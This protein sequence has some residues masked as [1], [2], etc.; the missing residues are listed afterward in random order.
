MN[1]YK[2]CVVPVDKIDN[3]ANE[4]IEVHSSPKKESV[5][6]GL[7]VS[8][9]TL[10]N[11]VLK[12]TGINAIY[13]LAIGIFEKKKHERLQTESSLI[14]FEAPVEE[15]I[16]W[17]NQSPSKAVKD[18]DTKDFIDISIGELSTA[19]PPA[20]LAEKDTKPLIL[21]HESD[22]S[23]RNTIS[24]TSD[25]QEVTTSA[26]TAALT[27]HIPRQIQSDFDRSVYFMGDKNNYAA[28]SSAAVPSGLLTSSES[29]SS[30]IEIRKIFSLFSLIFNAL[31][32]F[33]VRAADSS[34]KNKKVKSNIGTKYLYK[35]LKSKVDEMKPNL[36]EKVKQ[37]TVVAAMLAMTQV[38]DVMTVTKLL[39]EYGPVVQS[40]NKTFNIVVDN[41]QVKIDVHVGFVT[42]SDEE[43]LNI[44]SIRS[45]AIE[46]NGDLT[47]LGLKCTVN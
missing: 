46:A 17:G 21:N 16:G 40:S 3:K 13:H 8:F 2:M 47:P 15:D 23:L 35:H 27:L 31:S 18:W 1:L 26:E 25:L 37:K 33:P 34:V 42:H 38:Y 12:Y 22:N 44:D 20:V 32:P 5:W 41:N 14:D 10:V 6:M 24:E 9:M 28:D 19:L 30:K 29:G 39:N 4:Q 11:A 7:K 36:D 45:F 43:Q